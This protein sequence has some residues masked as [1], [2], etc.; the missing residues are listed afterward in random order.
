MPDLL[1]LLST[2]GGLV[3]GAIAGWLWAQ[4]RNQRE[5]A[6]SKLALQQALGE[7]RTDPL[8][9]LWNRRAFDE[10]LAIQTAV[11]QR[12][13]TP[14]ALILIDID[15]LKAVNDRAGHSAGDAALQQ[16]AD[17]LR[18][19]S[20]SADLAMRLGG[21]EF[22]LILPQTDL[23]GAL[24]VATRIVERVAVTRRETTTGGA[25]PLELRVS[26]GVA[27]HLRDE[28]T[29]DLVTRADQALYNAKHAGGHRIY[30][31]DGEV[32]ALHRSIDRSIL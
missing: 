11:A 20:R 15:D 14:C 3:I 25:A 17:L 18:D 8:T 19:S 24:I 21:D 31:H 30:M 7:A 22:A 13:D 32:A 28:A 9:K 5:Q 10:Q 6:R 4:K 26:L 23:A 29:A 2:A 16:L 12:Y 1:L 27:A